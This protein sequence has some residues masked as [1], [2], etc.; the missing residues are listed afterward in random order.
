MT[1]RDQY[2]KVFDKVSSFGMEPLKEEDL[3]KRKKHPVKNMAAAAAV[4]ILIAG[5]TGA[6]YAANVGG[7]QRKIQLWIRGDQ[8]DATLVVRDEDG[9]SQYS[10]TY[11]LEDGSTES[12]YGGGVAIEPDGTE[13]ALTEDEIMRDM[14]M[15]E[16]EYEEDG[17]VW[18]YYCDQKIDVTDSF[19]D[20]VCYVKLLNGSETVYMTIKYKNGFSVSR[21]K[22]P[23]PAMFN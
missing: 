8:T 2:K 22:Y 14:S 6:A 18:V 3:M 20:G 21:S 19:E 9:Y 16:V 10:V 5:S 23:D 11:E 13:R 17:S 12:I 4:L 7:I 1:G 15:P